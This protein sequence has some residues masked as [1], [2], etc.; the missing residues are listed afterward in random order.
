[1][2]SKRAPKQ[3]SLTKNEYITTFEAKGQNLQYS[4]FLDPNFAPLF[5]R[6]VSWLK[7]VI[8]FPPERTYV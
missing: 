1:M 3:W 6:Q 8:H 5:S 2:N 7:K 4:L